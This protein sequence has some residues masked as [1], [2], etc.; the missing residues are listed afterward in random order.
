MNMCDRCQDKVATIIL[1]DD[2]QERLCGDC[3]NDMVSAEMGVM[4]EAMPEEIA[5]NDYSGTRRN[6]TVQ[7]RLYPNG[8]FLEAVA[9][10]EYGYQFAVD[11]ELECNQSELFQKLIDKVK[12]GVSKRFIKVGE[13]PNGQKYHSIIDDEVVGRIDHDEMSSSVPMIVIDGQP[14]TWE[15]LGEMVKSYEG[16]QIQMKFFDMTD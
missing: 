3:F 13:F 1:T 7:R 4:L 16:F 2:W 12:R 15:Q 9:D 6:F 14:Y 11:G 10:I 8:I 5:V